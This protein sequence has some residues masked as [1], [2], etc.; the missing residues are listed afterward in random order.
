MNVDALLS[1]LEKDEGF[2][3]YVYD[4]ANGKPIVPGYTLVGHPTIWYGLCLEQ[5][6]IPQ[7]PT[8]LP[9]DLLRYVAEGKWL[10]LLMREPWIETLPEKT[11]L[12]LA[13]MA[14][15]LGARG[16]LNFQKMMAALRAGDFETAESEALDSDWG[17][18]H[19]TRAK[20]VARLI[21]G[22]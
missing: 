21:R 10:E 2:V 7:L 3:A 4:D 20:K 15:Q 16:V 14:Y 1:A 19:K 12:G 22:G 9:R 5:G 8:S 13:M 17:R 18:K 6:R 11:Q